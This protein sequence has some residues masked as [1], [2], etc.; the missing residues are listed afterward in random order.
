MTL[1]Q[2]NKDDQTPI[3]YYRKL[4]AHNNDRYAEEI[5]STLAPVHQVDLSDISDMAVSNTYPLL[6]KKNIKIW[7]KIINIT[8][9]TI[10]KPSTNT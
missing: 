8:I 10:S 9:K 3:S 6:F 7:D 1:C 5:L 2:W 4:H